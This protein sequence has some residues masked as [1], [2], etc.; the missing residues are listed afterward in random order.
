MKQV[1]DWQYII[2]HFDSCERTVAPLANQVHTS[3]VCKLILYVN[4]THRERK[5]TD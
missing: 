5:R 3:S 2:E 1:I 4:G